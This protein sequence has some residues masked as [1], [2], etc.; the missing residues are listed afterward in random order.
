MNRFSILVVDD[1]PVFR[2][3]L[4]ALLSSH[5]GWDICGEAADGR[6][7]VQKCKQLK[8]DLLI[9]DICMPEL[10]GLDAA[11]QI[12]KHNPDQAILVLTAVDSEDVIRECL[13]AG[14]RGWVFKSEATRD[15]LT[16]VEALQQQKTIFSSR[17][18]DLIMDGYKRHRAAPAPDNLTRLSPREREVVQLVSEGKASKEIA[19]ILHMSLSTAE[20]HRSNILRKLR[21]HSIAELVM[22]AV[23]NGIVHVHLPPV[24]HIP[25]L[26]TKRLGRPAASGFLPPCVPGARPSSIEAEGVN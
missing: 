24:L 12:L 10:N 11:R 14:I 20:T 9:L 19:T 8:P 4:C 17:V 25:S 1:H 2:F 26:E 3:G 21:L 22:Y 13:E 23:R 6:D 15:L 5:Q 18:S 7:A 16:A